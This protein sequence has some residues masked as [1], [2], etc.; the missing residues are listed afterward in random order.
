[1]IGF[2][3]RCCLCA[4]LLLLDRPEAAARAES[5]TTTAMTLPT[6]AA[7][8]ATPAPAA[9]A[10]PAAPLVLVFTPAAADPLAGRLEA[11]LVALGMSVR[12]IVVADEMTFVELV[13]A[14]AAQHAR[15]AIRV[16]AGGFGAEVWIPDP[17]TGRSVLRQSLSSEST[18]GMESVIVLRT[19]E[20]LRASLLP[21]GV[22]ATPATA[23]AS[24]SG[25]SSAPSPGSSPAGVTANPS[26]PTSPGSRSSP[27][28]RFT[29]APAV[30]VS[31]GGVGA[32]PS[33]AL[34]INFRIGRRLGI[35]AVGLLPVASPHLDTAAGSIRISIALVGAGAYARWTLSERWSWEL[36]AGACA[37]SV[38]TEGIPRGPYL[39]YSDGA[40]GLAPY[41]RAG[42]ALALTSW[43]SL[44][45]DLMAGSLLRRTV[46]T[47]SEQGTS[48]DI[49][50]WGRPFATALI[51]LQAGWF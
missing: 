38:Q 23:P 50:T 48:Q 32:S 39:G 31:P 25:S 49:A 36:A 30:V 46:I 35:E 1:V 21:S 15:G 16:L 24:S 8:P 34:A 11:E 13:P 5:A 19:V 4:A 43:L 6:P 33:T 42:A 26:G 3:A 10:T 12:R 29:A 7:A 14:V 9:P 28:L 45:A 40:V 18:E 44:R 37:I 20:F 27:R 47:V 41:A 2:S 51:G 22:S 17:A